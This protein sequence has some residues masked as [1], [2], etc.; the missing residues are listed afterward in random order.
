MPNGRVLVFRLD[1]TGTLEFKEHW[2]PMA[3]VTS[4]A[5]GADQ[6]T[7]GR[8]LYFGGCSL[9]H[10]GYIVPDLRRSATIRNRDAFRAIV[11]DGA[12]AD[13]GMASWK[14]YL[15]P[16][17]AEDIRAYVNDE[18]RKLAS[19]EKTKAVASR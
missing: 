15:T 2:A 4:E 9:C 3:V 18:A 16:D 12:L 17:Q 13:R 8:D 14:N 10:G 11:L 1:A 6:V 19:E 5:F 7:R